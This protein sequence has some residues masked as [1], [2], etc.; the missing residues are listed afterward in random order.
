MGIYCLPWVFS[1]LN[2]I[3]I[4]TFLFT[5]SVPGVLLN[6]FFFY[7]TILTYIQ[8]VAQFFSYFLP[9]FSPRIF[10]YVFLPFFKMCRPLLYQEGILYSV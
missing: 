3:L 2:L 5:A 1:T 4:S 8:D 9:N 6:I 10:S 7:P